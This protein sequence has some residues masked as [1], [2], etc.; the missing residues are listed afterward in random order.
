MFK[1]NENIMK[2]YNLNHFVLVNKTSSEENKHFQ[3]KGDKKYNRDIFLS[4]SVL[5]QWPSIFR[6]YTSFYLLNDSV[7]TY[8]LFP[9]LYGT[10]QSLLNY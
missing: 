7:R 2:K 5:G 9:I 3:M 6:E 8:S 1:Q 4:D 10:K